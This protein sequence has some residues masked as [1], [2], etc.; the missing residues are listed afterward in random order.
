MI[1]EK[2]CL[3]IDLFDRLLKLPDEIQMAIKEGEL[4]MGHARALVNVENSENQLA[5]LKEKNKS[6]QTT[7]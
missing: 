1:F 5:I 7:S 6:F 4:M 2:Q 3:N